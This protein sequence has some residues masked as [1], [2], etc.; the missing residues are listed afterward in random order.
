MIEEEQQVLPTIVEETEFHKDNAM[1]TQ[2]VVQHESDLVAQISHKPSN[3]MT[4]GSEN[5]LPTTGETQIHESNTK[6]S[7]EEKVVVEY[8]S[9]HAMQTLPKPSN[10]MIEDN[11]NM[12]LRDDDD[13]EGSERKDETNEELQGTL[14]TKKVQEEVDK[15]TSNTNKVQSIQGREQGSEGG[16]KSKG[17]YFFNVIIVG[18]GSF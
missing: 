3:D 12:P 10:N 6:N 17:T 8:Q 2:E 4:K 18:Y 15:G 11:R 7:E 14:T 1:S 5:M 16:E 9:D 13:V